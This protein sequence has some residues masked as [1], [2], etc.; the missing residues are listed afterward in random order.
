MGCSR[1]LSGVIRV[2]PWKLE[3]VGEAIGK[4]LRMTKSERKGKSSLYFGIRRFT[5]VF[6]LFNTPHPHPHPQHCTLA[7]KAS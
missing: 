1:S 7:G 5:N 4:A 2:N 6:A 3:E